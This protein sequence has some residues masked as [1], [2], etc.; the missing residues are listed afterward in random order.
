MD[1]FVN[2]H[3]LRELNDFQKAMTNLRA[4]SKTKAQKIS[5]LQKKNSIFRFIKSH[6]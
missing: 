4:N 1:A 6:I 5:A 2:N 3:T